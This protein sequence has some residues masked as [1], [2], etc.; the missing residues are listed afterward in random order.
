MVRCCASGQALGETD[1]PLLGH[2]ALAGAPP[3]SSGNCSLTT[4]CS[5][6]SGMKERVRMENLGTIKKYAVAQKL[7]FAP[8]SILGTGIHTN[9]HKHMQT[10]TH[11][12]NNF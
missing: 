6:T 5:K 11:T 7:N 9:T 4:G 12:A 2:A 8:L 10:D 1:I 3:E